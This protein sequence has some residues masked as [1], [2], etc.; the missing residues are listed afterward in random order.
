MTG[1]AVDFDG[2]FLK[3]FY[4]TYR[5][6][7]VGLGGWGVGVAEVIRDSSGGRF[8]AS[9]HLRAARAS[10]WSIRGSGSRTGFDVGRSLNLRAFSAFVLTRIKFKERFFHS[11][12]RSISTRGSQFG[13]R[14][15]GQDFTH[16]IGGRE[17]LRAFSLPGSNSM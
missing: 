2:L 1:L 6:C 10:T 7:I 17:T 15:Q 14:A 3:A 5:F 4:R 11:N 12:H 16:A 9:G 8:R 13:D